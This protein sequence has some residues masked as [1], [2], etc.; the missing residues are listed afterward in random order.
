MRDIF[1]TLK[2]A[3]V[4]IR[5]SHKMHSFNF[6]SH[7]TVFGRKLQKIGVVR[8]HLFIHG[9][10]PELKLYQRDIYCINSTLYGSTIFNNFLTL[11]LLLSIYFDVDK[12]IFPI[13]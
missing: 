3:S 11:Y 7:P 6:F 8:A 10:N 9:F 4:Y 1:R 2:V 5:L 12:I 13:K